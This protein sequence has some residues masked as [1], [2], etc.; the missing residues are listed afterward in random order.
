MIIVVAVVAVV[1]VV[2][3][4]VVTDA[5]NIELPIRKR[6]ASIKNNKNIYLFFK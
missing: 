1:A 5:S 2:V 4:V 6:K 3:V